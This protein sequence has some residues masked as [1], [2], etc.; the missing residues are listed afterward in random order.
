M[1]TYI[2]ETHNCVKQWL[3]ICSDGFGFGWYGPL[4]GLYHPKTVE[5]ITQRSGENTAQSV[6]LHELP[7]SLAHQY[8]SNDPLPWYPKNIPTCHWDHKSHALNKHDGTR[9]MPGVAESCILQREEASCSRINWGQFTGLDITLFAQALVSV[10]YRCFCRPALYLV[11]CGV[12]WG[13]DFTLS[14][15]RYMKNYPGTAGR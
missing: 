5:I 8:N 3:F 11:V 14:S 9:S 6:S 4:K 15:Y 1:V 2:Y 12:S 10:R 7:V 13:W